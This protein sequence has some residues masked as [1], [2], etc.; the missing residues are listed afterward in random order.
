M[1]KKYFLNE[2]S[3]IQRLCIV[4]SVFLL[5]FTSFVFISCAEKTVKKS[6][7][8]KSTIGTVCTIT[9][10]EKNPVPLFDEIFVALD[11]LEQHVSVNIA[12]S[13]ISKINE[14]AGTD[15]AISV[16]EDT[17]YIL[18]AAIKY[19]QLTDGAFDPSIG[20]L[21]A[22]WGIGTEAAHI[23]TKAQIEEAVKLVDYSKI[24]M[25]SQNK[26]VYLPVKGMRLDLGGIA[27]GYAADMIVQI[28]KEHGS[29]KAIID[30]GG[31]I[32]AY[33]SKTP[34]TAWKVGIK[35]P[36]DS[37]GDPVVAIDLINK[38]VVTSGVYERFFIKDGIRYHH[39]LDRK[40]GYPVRN[41]LMSATIITNSSMTADAL[42]TAVFVLGA[43][44]GIAFLE[45]LDEVEGFCIDENKKI[46]TT[47]GIKTKLVVI[48]SS[49]SVR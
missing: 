8:T 41:G 39:L 34:Q 40:T 42:S 16:N 49:F 4:I 30:L 18:K 33:G 19:A 21:V 27:K 2:S 38:T 35:N 26:S 7:Q 20:P 31:N 48:D 32:Y 10:Y 15:N 11:L 13:D 44:K 36:Y 43:Q 1:S 9:L 28:L 45:S 46:T 23:P 14:A 3:L 47:S 25:D 17:F 6:T 37:T 22:L 29:T 5:I 24:E 12:T